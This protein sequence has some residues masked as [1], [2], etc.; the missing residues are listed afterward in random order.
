MPNYSEF[1]DIFET[2]FEAR[3]VL[4]SLLD[5][6]YFLT[7][8]RRSYGNWGLPKAEQIMLHL[9]VAIMKHADELRDASLWHLQHSLMLLPCMDNLPILTPAPPKNKL[10]E[11]EPDETRLSQGKLGETLSR[12]APRRCDQ[13]WCGLQKLQVLGLLSLLLWRY[14]SPSA[15]DVATYAVNLA[16]E[17][18]LGQSPDSW[19][20]E[21][22]TWG[23]DMM[24]CQT[25]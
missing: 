9:V 2:L 13:A 14:G 20:F 10:A 8:V 19:P 1:F 17:Q 24:E 22:S 12:Q 11:N 23:K 6:E 3:A 16:A 18:S 7:T 15:Q 4:S 21:T 5:S 25:E